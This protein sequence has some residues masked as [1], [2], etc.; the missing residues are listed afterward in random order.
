MIM[1]L[2]FENM[3]LVCCTNA[4]ERDKSNTKAMCL[5]AMNLVTKYKQSCD[6]DV[7]KT[8][9]NISERIRNRDK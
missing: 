8:L 9:M 1:N 5:R 4:N 6:L 2:E 7:I 3:A